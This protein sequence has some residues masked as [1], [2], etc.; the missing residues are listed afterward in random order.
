MSHAPGAGALP[1]RISVQESLA[2]KVLGKLAETVDRGKGESTGRG[3]AGVGALRRA[4]NANERGTK[5][6]RQERGSAKGQERSV[7][8]TLEGASKHVGGEAGPEVVVGQIASEEDP[9]FLSLL[10]GAFGTPLRGWLVTLLHTLMVALAL[11]LLE[12]S[13]PLGVVACLL[14]TIELLGFRTRLV[15]DACAGRSQVRWPE[16]GQLGGTLLVALAASLWCLVPAIGLSLGAWGR[17]AFET[18]S[19]NSLVARAQRITNPKVAGEADPTRGFGHHTLLQ[20][21]ALT[22]PTL[23]APERSSATVIRDLQAGSRETLKALV[24]IDKAGPL[25]LAARLFLVLGFLVYPMT[26]LSAVR[27]RSVYAAVYPPIVVRAA[28]TAPGAY[29]FVLLAT[30][31]FA[32][33][34]V[35]GAL[36]GLPAL[37]G[38]GLGPGIGHLLWIFAEASYLVVGHMVLAGLLGRVYLSHQL[39]LGWD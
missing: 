27:L 9:S 5:A 34:A 15:H 10:P 28:L 26:I 13:P 19:Q 17:P 30:L 1:P 16:A 31:I 29:L 24:A 38:L 4:I 37:H 6:R 14:A 20:L 39:A 18:P 35:A 36:L 21:E 23:G 25:G 11:F 8:E 12:I 2:G 32:V 7:D 22:T 33:G 3:S